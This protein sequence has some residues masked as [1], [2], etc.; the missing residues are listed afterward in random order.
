MNRII[1]HDELKNMSNEEILELIKDRGVFLKMFDGTMNEVRIKDIIG[2][3]FN[4]AK[5][6]DFV[7]LSFYCQAIKSI[8]IISDCPQ[9]TL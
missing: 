5:L 1:E 3:D 7:G 8:E 6:I 2:T 4:T 9:I